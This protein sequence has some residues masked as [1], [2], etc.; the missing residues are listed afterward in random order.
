MPPGSRRRLKPHQEHDERSRLVGD[1]V[2]HIF[3]AFK[4]IAQGRTKPTSISM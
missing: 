1:L 2:Q 4:G 3:P